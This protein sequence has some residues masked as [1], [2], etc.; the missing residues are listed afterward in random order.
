MSKTSTTEQEYK[1]YMNLCLENQYINDIQ[2]EHYIDNGCLCVYCTKTR[3]Y[4]FD[5]AKNGETHFE[6]IIHQETVFK[7]Q[8]RVAKS[9]VNKINTYKSILNNSKKNSK[10]GI[11]F[12]KIT[13]K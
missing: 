13:P 10:Y 5:C 11:N 4:I 12:G 6:K 8:T 7:H 2:N 9:I 1:F 3:K